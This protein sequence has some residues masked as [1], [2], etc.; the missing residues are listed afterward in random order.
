MVGAK[1]PVTILPIPQ[2]NGLNDDKGQTTQ[3][4]YR[5][6]QSIDKAVRETTS[7][8]SGLSTK[9][10]KTQTWEQPFYI[11]YPEDKDYRVSVKAATARTITSVTTICTTGTA[12]LTAYA[13]THMVLMKVAD[14]A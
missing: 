5:Y 14:S 13:G 2:P 6:L 9:A 10:A 11:E 12:T 3:A 7:N 1:P 8:L 4:G